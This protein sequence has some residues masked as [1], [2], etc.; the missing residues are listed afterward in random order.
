MH[1]LLLVEE[2][3]ILRAA[4]AF[5][6]R[7][8]EFVVYTAGDTIGALALLGKHVAIAVVV[9]EVQFGLASADGFVFAASVR[10]LHA[11]IGII[12]LTGRADL[13]IGRVAGAHEAHLIKPCPTAR[14]VA[15]IRRLLP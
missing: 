10:A 14:I 13:L 5:A 12:F 7:R 1:E 9:V 6:L 4:M 2:H 15:A 11:D 3:P 8:E